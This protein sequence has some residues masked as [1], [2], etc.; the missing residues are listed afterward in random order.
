MALIIAGV[1]MHRRRQARAAGMMS[2][3]PSSIGTPAINFSDNE[4]YRD[5]PTVRLQRPQG[6]LLLSRQRINARSLISSSSE[7]Y[8]NDPNG[9]GVPRAHRP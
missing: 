4:L 2:D 9:T 3:M 7:L 1:L 6:S 8:N 5:N